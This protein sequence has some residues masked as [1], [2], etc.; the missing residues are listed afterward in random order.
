METLEPDDALHIGPFRALAVLGQGGM[1]RVLLAASPD[2]RLVAVKQIHTH[3][4]SD[5]G[6]RARFRREVAASQR[7]SGAYTAAVMKA[8]AEAPTPWLASVFVPGP[9][10]GDVVE[11]AGALPEEAV[12]RLATGL[13]TALTEIHRV[14]LIHRDLKPDN[15]LITEDGVRVIDFGIARAVRSESST[16][17]TRTGWVVGS[18]S[19]M[20]PEQAESGELT[21]A[22]D[23]FSLGSIL[24]TAAT[25]RS[26]FT[27]TST[28]RTLYN[29]VHADPDLSG[30]PEGLRH[31]VARC[32]AKDPC[33]RPTPGELLDDLGPVAVGGRRWP[34]EVHRMIAER[35]AEVEV[36]V[37]GGA[38]GDTGT[39]VASEPVPVPE[40]ATVRRDVIVRSLGGVPSYL[41]A[42]RPSHLRWVAAAVAL[43]AVVAAGGVAA[44]RW[45]HSGEESA[46]GPQQQ[47]PS[48]AAPQAT[49]PA[50]DP[51]AQVQ[52][53]YL[54]N[55]PLS[56]EDADF[57]GVVPKGF[58]APSG[59][60]VLELGDAYGA[61][62]AESSC[63]WKN[64][65]GDKI[66]VQWNRY[67]TRPG[68]KSGAQS[69]KRGH[70]D[71]RIGA[72]E[73]EISYA[74]EG[75]RIESSNGCSVTARDVN[76][77]V[78]VAVSGPN[79]PAR[80]CDGLSAELAGNA[81]LMMT[82]R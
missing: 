23:I 51:L 15:V 68:V 57:G 31:V 5:P 41:P 33:D 20:S 55:K 17:L 32:L 67:P 27:A 58:G 53:R 80:S 14:G 16:E 76:L 77:R 69:A 45:A 50:P 71:Y 66:W 24:V 62:Y 36:L 46:G 47:T 4:A 72:T 64:P 59:G 65:S 42:R 13:T 35:K 70:D 10:L 56:C 48:A 3:L 78:F 6:F 29:V 63:T 39:L 34:P 79:Y 30:V 28:L 61:L 11:R 7:V 21:A 73:A 75:L 22:S 26:P 44:A 38:G 8:D 25:G 81:I 2:G 43:G 54:G 18:P 49:A 9:P 52:D 60:R 74:E 12:R 82:G 37:G 1:G 19:F 40:Q